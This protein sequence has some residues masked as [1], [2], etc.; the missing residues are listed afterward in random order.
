[1][2]NSVRELQDKGEEIFKKVKQNH[3]EVENRQGKTK[4]NKQTKNRS[5]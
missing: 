3:K 5:V 4:T 1:M 2:K